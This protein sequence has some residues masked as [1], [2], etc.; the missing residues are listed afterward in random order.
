M[1]VAFRKASI[2]AL[3]RLPCFAVW[4][5]PRSKLLQHALRRRLA[6]AATTCSA[7]ASS[8][9]TSHPPIPATTAT[10]STLLVGSKQDAAGRAMAEALLA[11]GNWLETEPGVEHD[12]TRN[13][14]AYR[15]KL[16]PTSLW[17]VEG[18]LLDLDDADR[19]WASASSVGSADEQQSQQQRE[20][21][22]LPSDV[23]FL[24]KHVAKSGV[25][26]LC[27]HPIGVPNPSSSKEA[28]GKPGRC[29]PPSPRLA[30]CLR[31]LCRAAREA[32]LDS[33]FDTTLEV[34]HHGPW[35]ETPAMF[36][37]IGSSEEHWGRADAAEVWASVLTRML[38]LDGSP[39]GD[40]N[41][42]DLDP[43]ARAERS[44]FVC[45]GGGHYAPKPGDLA[46]R[47]GSYVGHML[48]SYALD[49]GRGGGEGTWREAVTE[50]V[51]STRAAFPG[52]GGG[53]A[54]GVGALVDKK[55]FRARERAA[56]LEHLGTLGVEHRF[57][58]SEC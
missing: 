28:G 27:V 30:G 58:S 33:S 36:V 22:A 49:F 14:R 18:R 17:L 7:T 2:F 47:S 19:R 13:G 21:L 51:R 16:S 9:P 4:P 53:V 29:P 48:A 10:A 11:R 50:A 15:H 32:G 25:P 46:R 54:G 26:A 20:P 31:E 3:L 52:A 43:A 44:A 12:G 6:T 41:W 40:I 57:K 42:R 35:L 37:E 23:V 34:T 8:S 55:A 56:L 24:S 39:A 1:T 5:N 45:I 38:G